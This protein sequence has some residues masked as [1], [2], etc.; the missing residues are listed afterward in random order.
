[1]SLVSRAVPLRGIVMDDVIIDTRGLACPLP[2]L[3]VR[4]AMR[5][6][7]PGTN[8]VVL[9]TDPGAE[10]DLRAYCEASGSEFLT[11]GDAGGGVLR[12]VIRKR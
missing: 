12:I 4:K 6:Y 11:A 5:G 10:E 3:K 9:A 1:M 7:D 8:I 2:V